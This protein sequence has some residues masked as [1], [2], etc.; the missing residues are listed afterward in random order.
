MKAFAA[1]LILFV[2][3]LAFAACGDED[4]EFGDP[5]DDTPTP[6]DTS[7]PDGTTTPTATPTVTPTP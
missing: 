4:L 5:S 1:S 3:F 6:D 2:T 7:T